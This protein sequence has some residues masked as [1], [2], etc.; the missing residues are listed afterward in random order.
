VRATVEAIAD[1]LTDERGF[2]FRYRAQDG[3]AGEEGTFAI[4]TFWLVQ[5]LAV[6]GGAMCMVA[7]IAATFGT[8]SPAA[9]CMSNRVRPRSA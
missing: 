7:D 5:C 1:R 8:R 9:G 6:W 2:V 4:C 3:L